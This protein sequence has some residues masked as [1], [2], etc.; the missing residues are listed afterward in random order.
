MLTEDEGVIEGIDDCPCGRKGKYFRVLGRLKNAEIRGCSDTY[1]AGIEKGARKESST[2]NTLWSKVQFLVG[3]K[4]QILNLR[5]IPPIT[6]FSDK[7]VSFLEDVSSSLM[8][9]PQGKKW[10]DIVTLGFWLR[11]ASLLKM[12]D[13]FDSNQPGLRQGRGV[14]FHI[15]PSNV[16]VNFAYSLFA[17]LLCGNASVVRVP[18]KDFH[19]VSFIISAIHD[20]LTRHVEMK[21]YINLVRYDRNSEINDY[22]SSVCDTR[23]IW[24]GDATIQELRQSPL[25]PRANEITFADRYSIAVIDADEY[26]VREDRSAIAKAFYNDTYLSDQN[27]CTSPRMVVWIGESAKVIADEFWSELHAVVEDNYNFQEVMGVDKL[28]QL[29]LAATDEEGFEG[30][31][32]VPTGDNLIY[33]IGLDKVN[34]RIMDYRGNCGCFYEYF[35]DDIMEIR[36]VCDDMRCQ[37]VGL[38]GD[39]SILTPLFDSGIHGVDRVV[40]I[41]HT[42]DFDLVWDGYDLTRVLTREIS[43]R[44][45]KT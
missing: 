21:P 33:R 40:P 22:F 38:L 29:C 26:I 4:D 10:P 8:K 41:G 11:H 27:A 3:D 14:A 30:L 2:E 15:A 25:S 13:R 34:Q 32:L 18:S 43:V 42:M 19:Q 12:K 24:G 37:T 28:T 6:F 1:A 39:P 16:P 5:D 17:A 36:D 7:V 45:N 31:K 35:C 23:I 20:A 44:Q 9:D